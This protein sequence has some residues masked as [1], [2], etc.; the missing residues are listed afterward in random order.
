MGVDAAQSAQTLAAGA[1]PP[2]IR[3][4]DRL[5]IP[6]HHVGHRTATLD[7]NP[8]LSVDFEA[9]F[10]QFSGQL[11]IEHALGRHSAPEEAL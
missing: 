10:R 5:R 3:H 8:D 6:T 9:D 1:Q 4:F 7:Q 2:P 11:L